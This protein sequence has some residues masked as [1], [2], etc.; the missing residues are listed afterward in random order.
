MT[1][2]RWEQIGRI[3]E[4]AL[5]L[6][7]EKRH[8]YLAAACAEDS[9]LRS[10]VESLLASHEE[11]GSRFLN[12][13][14]MDANEATQNA[15]RVAVVPGRRIGPYVVIAEIGRGGM[16]EVFSARRAD[17][18]YEKKV[19]IKLVRSGYD[20][21]LILERFRGERQILASLDHPNIARLLDGGTTDDGIPY[22]VL[23]LVEGVPVDEYCDAHKLSVTER[24]QLFGQV[25]AAVQYAHQR[26][27]IHR[28]LKP[29]NIL[30]DTQG[31]P[32]LLDFGI[33]K[34]L[35]AS[36]ASEPTVLQPMTPEYA[37]PEQVRGEPIT[38]A[39]DVYSLGV[40]LY[41]LLTGRSPY[42]VATRTPASLAEAINN[43]EPERPS[44][45]VERKE[46]VLEA[47]E[48]RE[49]TAETVSSVREFTPLRLQRRLRGDLDHILLKALR[50]ESVKRYGTVEQ[51]AQDIRN[52][53]GGLPVTAR[54]GTSAYRAG[55]FM[56][57]H[58]AGVIAATAVLAILASGVG[59]TLREARIAE[60]N[61]LR[62]EARFNDVRSLANSLIFEIHDSI[63]DLPGATKARSL[64]V[65]KSLGYLDG[66]AKES[67][68]DPALLRE[69]AAGY[70]RLGDVQGTPGTS[71]LGDPAA[72]LVSLQ[73]SLQLREQ[74]A[75]LNPRNSADQ[76]ELAT[77][78]L[79]LSD[80]ERGDGGSL[81]LA[82]ASCKKGV[83]I[84]DREIIA[85]P[86][87]L[88]VISQDARGYVTLGVI[89]VGDGA[90]GRLGTLAEGI[91][92]LRTS[93]ER[94]HQALKL[95][96]GN[97]KLYGNEAIAYMA[98]GNAELLRADRPQ[99]LL[100][101]QNAL[102]TMQTHDASG[103]NLVMSVNK[104]TV[105]GKIGDVLLI[106]GKIPDAVSYYGMAERA[107]G[108]LLAAEPGNEMLQRTVITNSA[109][110]GLALVQNGQPEEGL[111]YFRKSLAVADSEPAQTPITHLLQGIVGIWLG[112]GLERE[113]R[114]EEAVQQYRKSKTLIV[115]VRAAGGDDSKIQTYQSFAM[116]CLSSALQKQGR[117]AEAHTEYDEIR[118][119][120][121]PLMAT[122]PGDSEVLYALA[123]TYT[124]LGGV[125]A[126]AGETSRGHQEKLVHWTASRDWYKKSLDTWSKVANPAWMTTSGIEVT[127][128][129]K[130]SH[131]LKNCDAKIAV[132]VKQA[133]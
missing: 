124:G 105:T 22:L 56:Q 38:T 91:A 10:E 121:E 49:L 12:M 86:Q 125:S 102:N 1:P 69:L 64:I 108:Q 106:Q 60:A 37:S 95:A 13:G 3:L 113:N 109:Q 110:L 54:K 103:S 119:I 65:Q 5:A 74:L 117:L 111:K 100:F 71:N 104:L 2:D 62:A 29:N 80:L 41:Q 98:L 97:L 58:K 28:D 61:G 122:D 133:P 52:H 85:S 15:R 26:L 84:L 34:L 83:A 66:L 35:D 128:P 116:I 17:G 44:S 25:C 126:R 127:V 131:L 93:L 32:K 6:E 16:G 87:D 70:A 36:G 55:K 94:T 88:R 130:V 43:H 72:A 75:A 132:L 107:A 101:Y 90:S 19:A 20:T 18:Q 48:V 76:V 123:E 112:V 8:P 57:R 7:A 24:L 89:H 42:T 27:V 40:I 92:E 115:G 67:A 129:E 63:R 23:E 45:S 81:P 77:A 78:Y 73:K 79:D 9:E 96:P 114:V 33:A 120:L 53:L 14:E 50:K 51:F 31:V 11:A 99:A 118:A 68:S 47:G 21:A 46:S 82:L 4:N 59:V 39:T 30:V